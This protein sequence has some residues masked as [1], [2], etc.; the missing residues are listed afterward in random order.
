LT[1]REE[2]LERWATFYEELY[3]DPN[4]CDPLPTSG[5]LPIPSITK[6]EITTAIDYRRVKSEYRQYLLGIYE[7]WWQCNGSYSS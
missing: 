6:E 2:I 4:T 7:S 1:S 5:D 3:D